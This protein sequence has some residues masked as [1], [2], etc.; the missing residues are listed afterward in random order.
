M[1]KEMAKIR[2]KF[3]QK[4]KLTGYGQRKY[5]WKMVY[6]QMLGY[7]VDFG[8]QEVVNLISSTKFSE[9]SVGYLA[10]SILLA[11]VPDL[12]QLILNAI[13]ND[14]KHG[15]TLSKALALQCIA[16]MGGIDAAAVKDTVYQLL[17]NPRVSKNVKKKAALS[18]LRV[19]RSSKAAL[20]IEWRKEIYKL[21][22]HNNVGVVMA[23][24]SL[25]LAMIS[26]HPAD[27]LAVLPNVILLL[28]KLVMIG[29]CTSDYVYC[30]TPAPWLQVRLLRMLQYLPTPKQGNLRARLNEVLKKI[31]SKTEFQKSVNKNN[32]D[33]SI[34]FEA[35]NLIIHQGDRSAPILRKEAVKLLGKFIGVRQPNIRCIG[36]GTM[37]RLAMLE[38]T[39]DLIKKHQPSILVSLKDADVSIRKHALDLLFLM[40]DLSN[41]LEIVQELLSF[42][43]AAGPE[44][45]EEMVLKIAILAERYA[46]SPEWYMDTILKLIKL[47]GDY[48]S[49]DVWY[50]AVQ[51]VSNNEPLQ[52][53]SVRIM[54]DALMQTSVHEMSVKCA[55]YLLGEYGY[56]LADDEADPVSGDDQFNA[57][58][59]HFDDVGNSSKAILLHTFGKM[60]NLYPEQAELL[61]EA[62]KPYTTS[63]D[64]ELQQRAV[65]YSVVAT[66][67]D[68]LSKVFE[69]IPPFAKEK[70]SNLLAKLSSNRSQTADRNAWASAEAKQEVDDESG[71]S[72][73]SSSGSKNRGAPPPEPVAV[74]PGGDSL[75][76][77][78]GEAVGV[79]AALQTKV[80]NLFRA[81]M[82]KNSGV[83]FENGIIQIG[84]KMEYRAHQSRIVLFFGNKTTSRL[85]DFSVEIGE[86]SGLQIRKQDH[87]NTL[88]AK[89]QTKV[90][91][92]V[93]CMKPFANSPSLTVKFKAGTQQHDYVL[94][95]P[96]TTFK[97]M[98]ASPLNTMDFEA[99]W[100]KLPVDRT[101]ESS[102]S[103][104]KS[105][106]VTL[107]N[108]ILS[109]KLNFSI[110]PSASSS[111]ISAAGVFVTG[112]MKGGQAVKV[113]TLVRMQANATTSSFIVTVKAVHPD[114][115]RAVH[116]ALE[117]IIG[118]R[119]PAA[120][121]PVDTLE[122]LMM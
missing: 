82:T 59:T 75:L 102:V 28:H 38:D 31:L 85:T 52:K 15:D 66:N 114:V 30:R 122:S 17:V 10:V 55:S 56:L 61:K 36:L 121:A 33:Y 93:M 37:A 67:S 109:E 27:N 103:C 64:M 1:D 12:S 87:A 84:T 79:D 25:L 72:R 101:V 78:E 22:D 2:K 54:Y 3:T 58:I 92:Q 108:R 68:M 71:V 42:L 16:N 18:L 106:D 113:G 70:K 86:M 19:V 107:W 20:P 111:V 97:F 112:T 35:V 43:E 83:V 99:R 81:L 5:V 46:P 119:K 63:M 73:E 34:L 14:L 7:E 13:S 60:I 69:F 77:F 11:N 65:E 6:M 23:S 94:R 115:A 90:N 9:K 39:S 105:I 120:P 4:S 98:A 45:K 104:D 48:V 40:C 57:L 26:S 74:Q 91:V 117:E 118:G 47:A 49:D 95:L 100:N 96:V 32:T 110:I 88:G 89:S 80:D 24:S 41:C 21:L 53:Y 44:I 76:D 50:R 51:I 29:S 116:T 62:I 8:A